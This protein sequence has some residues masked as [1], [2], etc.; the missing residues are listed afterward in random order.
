MSGLVHLQSKFLLKVLY[1]L[2]LLSHFGAW[3]LT[4][5][6]VPK[7]VLI[8][9]IFG[10]ANAARVRLVEFGTALTEYLKPENLW[11]IKV[12]LRRDHHGSREMFQE[13]VRQVRAEKA[14]I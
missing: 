9:V 10:E 3:W 4:C 7:R 14:S 5:F 6:L 12:D 13:N 11:L 1:K 2:L 8:R